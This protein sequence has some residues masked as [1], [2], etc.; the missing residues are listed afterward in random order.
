MKTAD[1][2]F[3]QTQKKIPGVLKFA[4][5][6]LIAAAA[7]YQFSD[8]ILKAIGGFIVKDETP[9]RS[10]AVV[11]L[12]SGVEYYPRLIEAASLYKRGFAQTVVINGNRKTDVLRELENKGFESCCPWYEDSLRILSLFGVPRSNI[13]WI[14]A[15]D[16]YDTISEAEA[17][18]NELIHKGFS[19][20]ILATSK[21][22][23]RRAHYIW[24]RMFKNKLAICSV[25]AK[26]DPFDQRAWWKD[27]RQIR[28][29]LAE[30]G[31]WIYCY[32]KPVKASKAH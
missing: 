24:Q 18:G 27:G 30:Y 10:D 19:R 2:R 9:V 16:A 14:S 31:A 5:F 23:S 11:V 32:W 13:I 7:V 1:Y 4:V 3:N 17:V 25:S 22:H 15:E 8:P 21:Y 12:N 28:W 29:V 20:I 6:I 26:S